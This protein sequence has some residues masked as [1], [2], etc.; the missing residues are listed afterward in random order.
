MS[1]FI[2]QGMEQ[3]FAAERGRLV[4]LCAALTGDVNV[5]E[6]LAQE[7][8]L[9]AWRS[10]ERLRDVELF[11]HWL[12]G[13]ARNVCLRWRRKQGQ[14]LAHLE[15]QSIQDVS[16]EEQFLVDDDIEVEL[17]RKELVELLDR[18]LALLPAETRE[19]LVARYVEESSLAEVAE[20]LGMQ[21][22]AV[23]MRLQRG[24]LALR[25][26]LSSEPARNGDENTYAEY[27]VPAPTVWEKTSIWCT[28]CGER[29]LMGRFSAAEGT[30]W[31]SCPDCG[32][33]SHSNLG[34]TSQSGMFQGMKRVKPAVARL[35]GWIHRY[36]RTYLDGMMA[37]CLRCG[38]MVPLQLAPSL[39]EID[40][41][42]VFSNWHDERGVYQ[43]CSDCQMY[44]WTSLE[45]LALASPEGRRFLRE[46]PRIQLLPEQIVERDGHEAFVTRFESLTEQARFEVVASSDRYRV[47]SINGERP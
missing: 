38:R 43:V 31:L 14:Q 6:D 29:H 11:S 41:G 15:L 21:T 23:A 24:K 37:P 9:E 44:N 16:L 35:R 18:S 42:H 47:L 1:Q 20:R 8:M 39:F 30:L 5:A 17:E 32:E 26:I 10:I 28:G 45:G 34:N 3:A 40:A 46:H 12:S 4:G 25:R 13:I 19:V 33:Y 2:L 36:Y 7:V 22:G 27:G